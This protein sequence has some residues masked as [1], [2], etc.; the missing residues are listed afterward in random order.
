M[1]RT[2]IAYASGLTSR[3]PHSALAYRPATA[4]YGVTSSFSI[5]NRAKRERFT[6][7]VEQGTGPTINVSVNTAWN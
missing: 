6:P 2:V 1:L 5:T 4:M 7:E 3:G